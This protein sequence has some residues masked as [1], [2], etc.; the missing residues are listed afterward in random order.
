LHQTQVQTR[1]RRL[2]HIAH[3]VGS[4]RRQDIFQLNTL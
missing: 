3:S 2:H 1:P 4:T